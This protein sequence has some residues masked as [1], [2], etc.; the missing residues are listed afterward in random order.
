MGV[1]AEM[2]RGLLHV[3]RDPASALYVHP[4]RRFIQ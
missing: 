4:A 2:E 3:L 1:M